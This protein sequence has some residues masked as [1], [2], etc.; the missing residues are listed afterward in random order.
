VRVFPFED[1]NSPHEQVCPFVS[2][3]PFV[4]ERVAVAPFVRPSCSCHEP[5]FP[6]VT[7]PSVLPPVVIACTVAEVEL[8]VIAEVAALPN[9]N[10]IPDTSNSPT[11]ASPEVA[12]P[13]VKVVA[14]GIVRVPV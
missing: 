5:V 8:N 14:A 7:L 2:N 3:V 13:I 11:F 6:S 4:T 9:V 10:V 12:S 1:S